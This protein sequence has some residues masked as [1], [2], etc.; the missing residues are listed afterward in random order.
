MDRRGFL[1]SGAAACAAAGPAFAASSGPPTTVAALPPR[2]VLDLE[3]QARALLGEDLFTF[4][5]SGS[6]AEWTLRENRRAFDRYVIVPEYLAGRGAPDPRATLLG[7]SL[8][9]PVLTAPM[10]GQALFH[11]SADAGMAEGTAAAGALM[12]LSGAAAESIEAVAAASK[13]PKWFQL[14]LPEDRG[15]A[16]AILQRAH[17]AGYS[18]VAFTIDALGSGNSEALTRSGFDVGAALARVRPP[19]TPPAAPTRS[20]RLL[21]WDDLAFVQK[22]SGLP[23]VLKGVLTPEL[24]R[25]A[26]ASGVAAVQVSNHGGRQT[27]GLPATLDVLPSVVQAVGGKVPVIVDGGIR[28]GVD[29]FKA[30]ALGAKAVAVGRPALYG[31]A[32][33]GKLG[34]QSVHER[35]KAELTAT[36]LAAG[37]DRIEQIDGRFVRRAAV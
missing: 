20:K 9:L 29:I 32:L 21:G 27:D 6:G 35:L 3:A 31:L 23:V 2:V 7:A 37:V 1:I 34:V 18:A 5:A 15:Q 14:Y 8:A 17:T 26:V 19:A 36:M 11:A 30:L 25:R 33:G 24:A 10:G 4:A 22:E 12:T 13:G 16:R 28:R